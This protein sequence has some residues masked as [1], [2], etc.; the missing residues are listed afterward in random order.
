M[1]VWRYLGG[2]GWG[3]RGASAGLGQGE[4][5]ALAMLSS[6]AVSPEGA[7]ERGRLLKRVACG[8]VESVWLT[9]LLSTQHLSGLSE[10]RRG[11]RMARVERMR[12]G[13]QRS[14][15][16]YVKDRRRFPWHL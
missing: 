14:S 13:G 4:R 3:A 15:S 1:T 9:D 12:T 6:G 8:W 10:L 16:V 11:E 7:R 2:S 5:G